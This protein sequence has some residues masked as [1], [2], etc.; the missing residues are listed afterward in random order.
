MDKTRERTSKVSPLNYLTSRKFLWPL[1]AWTFSL[2]GLVLQVYYISDQYFDYD[3]VTELAFSRSNKLKPPKVILCF[4][5]ACALNQVVAANRTFWSMTV[6]ELFEAS[7]SPDDLTDQYRIHSNTSYGSEHQG[8]DNLSDTYI[9]STKFLKR[10]HICYSFQLNLDI[11]FYEHHLTNSFLSP[12][13]YMMS[14][15]ATKL[16]CAFYMYYMTGPGQGFYGKSNSFAEVN[17]RII[18]DTTKEG[19]KNWVV[20][21]YIRFHRTLKGPPYRTNCLDYRTV[22]FKSRGHCFESCLTKQSIKT[23]GKVPFSVTTEVAIDLPLI[24]WLDDRNASFAK[25]LQSLEMYCSRQCKRKDC[26]IDE[27]VPVVLD[28]SKSTRIT[29]ELYP[30]TQPDISSH[31]KPKIT[32]IDFVTYLLSCVSFWLA[33][34]PLSFLLDNN[35]VKRFVL[36]FEFRTNKRDDKVF[37]ELELLEQSSCDRIEKLEKAINEIRLKLGSEL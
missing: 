26:V 29:Y 14:L 30:P 3:T 8:H 15:N 7:Y 23:L 10:N 19:T 13:F 27:Y 31:L 17:R 16:P 24:T 20:M 5:Q 12:R 36:R 28:T 21:S 22:G 33:L 25:Q 35:Y 34:S 2:F 37:S 18:N 1:F 4:P 11:E 32:L 6:K 9:S